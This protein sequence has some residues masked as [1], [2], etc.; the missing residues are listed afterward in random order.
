MFP[1]NFQLS[2]NNSGFFWPKSRFLL[3]ACFSISMVFFAHQTPVKR[4][5]KTLCHCP[6]WHSQ[7]ACDKEFCKK[8]NK[9]IFP[10]GCDQKQ[11]EIEKSE[12]GG[13]NRPRNNSFT[14][15]E[16]RVKEDES[17]AS[18]ILYFVFSCDWR[19][20]KERGDK[21]GWMDENFWCYIQSFNM[22]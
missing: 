4:C 8:K 16:M 11:K 12:N 19:E 2:G 22:S 18:R 5:V 9:G 13:Q 7:W 3:S 1:F 21:R 17:N 14:P 6:A 15:E 20:T 10:V